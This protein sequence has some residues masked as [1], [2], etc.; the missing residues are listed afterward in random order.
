MTLLA[1]F[2]RI[3]KLPGLVVEVTFLPALQNNGNHRRELAKQ[4]EAAI[5]SALGIQ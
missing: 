1:S 3:A 2:W 4:A 5:R